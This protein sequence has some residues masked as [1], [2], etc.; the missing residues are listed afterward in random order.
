MHHAATTITP[1]GDTVP[2]ILYEK[3]GQPVFVP[4]EIAD[5]L[6][7]LPP[8]NDSPSF[9]DDDM[10]RYDDEDEDG[11]DR[12]SQGG[13]ERDEAEGGRLDGVEVIERKR[14]HLPPPILLDSGENKNDANF[15]W[16]QWKSSGGKLV[17]FLKT[18][19]LYFLLFLPEDRPSWGATA[20]K[21]L[22]ILSLALFVLL[23]GVSHPQQHKFSRRILAGLLFSCVG[24]A[25]LIWPEYFLHG[26][27]AFG[28]AQIFYI[29]AFGF[30]PLNAKLGA[31][32]YVLSSTVLI[33]IGPHVLSE[34][35]PVAGG[36]FLY[37]SLLLTM[38]WRA[39]SRLGA[40]LSSE[41]WSSLC[42]VAGG[43]LF[44]ISDSVLSLNRFYTNIPH[45]Q[46][47]IMTTYYAAQLAIALSILR[48][49][50]APTSSSPSSSPLAQQHHLKDH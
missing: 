37:S 30:Q 31:F 19:A 15:L 29:R 12:G 22:P 26:M 49:S 4:P 6:R 36:V 10:F 1:S 27:A 3:N 33:L 13:D 32:I 43:L 23:H 5:L 17:P 24:D 7:D 21:C 45:H 8:E 35:W 47:V 42:G 41:R 28:V 38:V 20:V 16:S 25:L 48:P 34:S 46:G 11:D 40:T 14:P 50:L 44:L 2:L 39:T 18:L 9:E